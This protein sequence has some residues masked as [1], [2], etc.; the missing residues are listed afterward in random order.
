MAE[1]VFSVYATR[2]RGQRKFAVDM[3]RAEGEGHINCK[4]PMT[5]VEGRIDTGNTPISHGLYN[6]CH[7]NAMTTP[8]RGKCAMATPW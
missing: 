4:L 8:A 6:I 7:G 3:A 1:R 2:D 5:E